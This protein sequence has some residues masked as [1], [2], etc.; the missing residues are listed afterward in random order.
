MEIEV[1]RPQKD[2]FIMAE[3]A[4]K[5]CN[6]FAIAAGAF[7]LAAA[8]FG[9]VIPS[10]ISY[11][12]W[13]TVS[14]SAAII[15]ALGACISKIVYACFV[16]DAETERR[17]GFVDNAFNVKLSSVKSERYY[18]T[19]DIP[20]GV[21]KLL[22]DMHQSCLTTERITR[23]MRN[24]CTPRLVILAI[25]L[26]VFAVIGFGK[27]VFIEPILNLLVAVFLLRDTLSVFLLRR[28]T[29]EIETASRALW[30]SINKH[31][32]NESITAKVFYL[33]IRYECALTRANIILDGKIYEQT[34]QELLHEWEQIRLRYDI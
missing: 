11:S 20:F 25:I 32:I 23:L 7:A 18:D 21:T 5:A 10:M 3:K 22:A 13:N 24:R 15:L 8:I 29:K 30:E 19:D 31:G 26:I 33:V 14:T 9:K 6:V 17:R 27:V 2:H 1:I 28:E 12:W 34:R 4:N 16:H